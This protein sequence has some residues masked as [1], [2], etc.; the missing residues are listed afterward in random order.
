M[1]SKTNLKSP[2][3][4]QPSH[5]PTTLHPIPAWKSLHFSSKTSPHPELQP[6]SILH[7]GQPIIQ[8]VPVLVHPTS[9]HSSWTKMKG[10]C[11]HSHK[12]FHRSHP[13]VYTAIIFSDWQTCSLQSF[14]CWIIHVELNSPVSMNISTPPGGKSLVNIWQCSFGWWGHWGIFS[15]VCFSSTHWIPS[16]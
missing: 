12:V 16:E 1:A 6:L 2:P 10:N 9:F 15:D 3:R 5:Q 7:L 13:K 14:T 8:L 4:K 11:T